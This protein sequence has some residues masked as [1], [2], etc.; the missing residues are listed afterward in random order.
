MD[1]EDNQRIIKMIREKYGPPN[2][3]KVER[4]SNL[5]FF[6]LAYAAVFI[7]LALYFGTKAGG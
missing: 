1:Y 7:G 6:W 2:Q 3:A 4:G 5:P